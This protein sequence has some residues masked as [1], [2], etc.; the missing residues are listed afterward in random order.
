MWVWVSASQRIPSSVLARNPHKG[1]AFEITYETGRRRVKAT[2]QGSEQK[3]AVSR[4]GQSTKVKRRE[5]ELG[6]VDSEAGL[7][8]VRG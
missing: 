5:Q 7:A 2:S 3:K 4:R 8:N 1:R 6:P